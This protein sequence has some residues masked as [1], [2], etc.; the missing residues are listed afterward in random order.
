MDEAT[1]RLARMVSE[2]KMVEKRMMKMRKGK[3]VMVV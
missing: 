1:T 2:D 3:T